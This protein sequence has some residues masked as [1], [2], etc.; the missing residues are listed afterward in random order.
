MRILA[1]LF[2]L[3]ALL[4][5]AG[6]GQRAEAAQP[7]RVPAYDCGYL[8]N[9]R[10]PAN[11]WQ[12]LFRGQRETLFGP[13]NHYWAAPCFKTQATCKAWLYWAQSDWPKL[14]SFQ[15]CRKGIPY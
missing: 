10:G 12:T 7:P 3:A 5:L 11:V 2:G 9:T 1:G 6:A 14:N 4:V 15:P 8:A 13:D